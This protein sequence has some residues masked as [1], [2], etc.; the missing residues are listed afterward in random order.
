MESIARKLSA[1]DVTK[2]ILALY[3]LIL[4]GCATESL[5]YWGEYE[6]LINQMYI[7][8]GSADP[9]TQIAKLKEDIG[10]AST[11]GK[12]VPPGLHAHLGYMYFLQGDT[13]SAMLEF[14]T[15]KKLFPEA[16]TFVDGLMNRAE[17]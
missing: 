6:D 9:A 1:G 4:S 12:L 5:Y 3:C 2:A 17:K 13:H 7:K 16:A 11:A 10:Q 8:P 15:E 14:A